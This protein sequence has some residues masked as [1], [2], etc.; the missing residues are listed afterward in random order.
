M[1]GPWDNVAEV[2]AMQGPQCNDAVQRSKRSKVPGTR[3]TRTLGVAHRV[4]NAFSRKKNSRA[5]NVSLGPVTKCDKPPLNN[6]PVQR[7]PCKGPYDNV[8][9]PRTSRKGP[10]GECDKGPLAASRRR[11]PRDSV[12]VAKSPMPT[13]PMPTSLCK[14]PRDKVSVASTPRRP[15]DQGPCGTIP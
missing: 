2:S 13:S 14:G 11:G 3:A 10:F 8:L 9:A 15:L 7:S 1:Q 5:S 4:Q 12:T 6:V